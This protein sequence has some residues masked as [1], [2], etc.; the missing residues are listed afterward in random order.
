MLGMRWW[1]EFLRD[2]E[3]LFEDIE[4]ME[5]D[6][7]RAFRRLAKPV[8]VGYERPFYEFRDEAGKLVALFDI[9]GVPKENIELRVD[10][11]EIYLKAE[12][13]SRRYMFRGAWPREVRPETARASYRNGV[14]EVSAEPRESA[15]GRR[16]A[17]E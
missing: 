9:P 8:E 15:K 16:V 5:R 3:E 2:I 13:E 6:V 12:S 17:I 10:E 7:R 14:L 11:R 1:R 4:E